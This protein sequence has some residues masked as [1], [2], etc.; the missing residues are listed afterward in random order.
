[1]CPVDTAGRIVLKWMGMGFKTIIIGLGQI[2]MGYDLNLEQDTYVLSHARAF[3]SHPDFQMVAGVDP[4]TESRRAFEQAY[5]CPAYADIDAAMREHSPEIVV[6]AL[7]T[8]QHGDILQRVLAQSDI[9]AVLCEKPLSYDLDEARS[10]VAACAAADSLLYVNYMRRSVPG[11]IE[12][13]RRIDA[14]EIAA[15]IK[16]VVWY[17]KG[18]LHNGSHFFNLMEYWLGSMQDSM[19]LN[20]GRLWDECDPEP[21][22]KV[23][24]ERGSIVFMAAWEEAFS[25]Y[26]MEL[27]SP[28]GRLRCEL[29][30]KQV[31][32]QPARCDSQIQG[33]SRL[34]PQVT[35]IVSGMDRYQWSVT[36]ELTRALHGQEAQL[37]TGAEALHTLESMNRIL[38]KG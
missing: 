16:G 13:K 32:W 9:K 30:G 8:A 6:I 37:C 35:D 21:D 3:D 31:Y 38:E 17:S 5:Q 28:D 10:M 24:F 29:G 20:K 34:S 33:Y 23:V 25:H 11:M 1:M 7:P 19:L 15:P 14:G 18:F 22:V 36:E 26:T 2:G 27:L 12:I 4:A